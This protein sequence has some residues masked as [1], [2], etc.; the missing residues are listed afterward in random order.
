MGMYD[1]I[2]CRY[3]L[4][5]EP[6]SF[7]AGKGN[8]FQSKSLDCFM[9]TYEITEAGELLQTGNMY[10]DLEKPETVAFHGVLEFYDSNWAALAFGVRF[11]ASG[12]DFES[13]TYEATFVNGKVQSIAET[14][15][16][17]EPALARSVLDEIDALFDKGEPEVTMTEPEAGQPM[18]LQ[19]GGSIE[20]YPVTFLAKTQVNWAVADERGEIDKLH[21]FDLGRLLFH[22][23]EESDRVKA[24]SEKAREQK[25]AYAKRL[26]EGRSAPPAPSGQN[27]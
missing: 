20:G 11:T 23:K 14:E 4:P 27:S 18:Y 12:E 21:P 8:R 1:H 26:L 22:S 9:A 13:V 17:R 24:W 10:G 7:C 15:R 25:I 2:I 6:P 16:E 5:G 3:P 19:W